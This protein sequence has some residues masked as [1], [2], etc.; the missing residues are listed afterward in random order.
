VSVFALFAFAAVATTFAVVQRAVKP[1]VALTATANRICLGEALDTQIES[2]SVEEIGSC[3]R[4]L[5]G[6]APA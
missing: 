3:P 2:H 5:T 6:S 1:A 4:R